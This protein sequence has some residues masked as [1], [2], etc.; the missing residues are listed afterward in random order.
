LRIALRGADVEPF[1]LRNGE[2]SELPVR[3]KRNYQP[4]PL[5]QYDR[6]W[7]ERIDETHHL[8]RQGSMSQA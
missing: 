4:H 6:N 1:A 2:L 7:R 3:I 5:D 8:R